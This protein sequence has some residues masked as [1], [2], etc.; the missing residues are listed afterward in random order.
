MK[1]IA[2][3]VFVPD[4]PDYIKQFYGL[5]Y[6]AM[7]HPKL[8]A[9]LEFIIGCEPS[10]ADQLSLDNVVITHTREIS[11]EP[12]FQFKLMNNKHNPFINSWSHFVDENSI[13]KILE[14]RYAH[15]SFSSYSGY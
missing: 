3:I 13:A 1:K 4:N 11:K 5:Y 12:D 15:V 14:Y 6:S 9:N 8:R 7:L 2:V 10:I